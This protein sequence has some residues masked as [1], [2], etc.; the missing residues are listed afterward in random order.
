MRSVTE[1]VDNAAT[2]SNLTEHP[3]MV[4]M[5]NWVKNNYKDF[6]QAQGHNLCDL[7]MDFMRC[8]GSRKSK[9][10]SIG[11]KDLKALLEECLEKDPKCRSYRAFGAALVEFV[12]E[13]CQCLVLDN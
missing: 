12:K 1:A 10:N 7:A 2:A 3:M 6:F 8:H 5:L 9:L 13:N 4:H 11:K